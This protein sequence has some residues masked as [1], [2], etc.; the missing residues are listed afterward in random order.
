MKKLNT[1]LIEKKKEVTAEEYD[2]MLG[3]LPPER[4]SGNAFLVG[5]ATDHVKVGSRYYPRFELYF[6]HS[7]RYYYG[8]LATIKDFE[9][10][11]IPV[12][13]LCCKSEMQASGQC[14]ACG[15]DGLSA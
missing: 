5:E 4:M 9:T 15:A 13:S 2:E 10:F 1:L 12:L 11:L 3:V 8:G 14:L 7:G 6:Q